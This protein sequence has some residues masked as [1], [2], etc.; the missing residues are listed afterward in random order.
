MLA[1]IGPG[2]IVMVGDN[3][4]GGVSTCVQAGQ[5]YGYSLL[6]VQVL[7]LIPVLIVNQEMVVRLGVRSPG[8]D[9]PG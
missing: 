6:W 2:L 8:S 7:L 3:D 4:A 9:T 1:I 5:N